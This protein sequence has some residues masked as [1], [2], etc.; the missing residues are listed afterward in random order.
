ML[1]RTLYDKCSTPPTDCKESACIKD[2]CVQS[3]SI[4]QEETKNQDSKRSA[5]F[6]AR[7]ARNYNTESGIT[8]MIVGDFGVIFLLNVIWSSVL[9]RIL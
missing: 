7:N 9:C 3:R 5:R 4:R 6:V 1:K 2:W 8:Y